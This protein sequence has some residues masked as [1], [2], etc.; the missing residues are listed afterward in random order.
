MSI[1]YKIELQR[2]VNFYKDIVAAPLYST[3]AHG[4]SLLSTEYLIYYPRIIAA[5]GLLNMSL[6]ASGYLRV[7]FNLLSIIIVQ[8]MMLFFAEH[9]PIAFV[10]NSGKL[11]CQKRK[12]LHTK[13]CY[14]SYSFRICADC[15]CANIHFVH[16]Q[17][18]VAREQRYWREIRTIYQ[19]NWDAMGSSGIVFG[20]LGDERCMITSVTWTFVCTLESFTKFLFIKDNPIRP[21]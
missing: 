6:L 10:P 2:N 9:A 17:L 12:H 4:L 13:S 20:Q 3:Y 18:L 16:N 1:N 11:I 14:S 21:K 7:T 19:N 15:G 5:I 8:V